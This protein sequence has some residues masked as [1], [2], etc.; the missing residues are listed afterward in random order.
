MLHVICLYNG[1]IQPTALVFIKNYHN[2]R[3]A[4]TM[5]CW[6]AWGLRFIFLSSISLRITTI[7]WVARF[8][9]LYKTQYYFRI[10]TTLEKR[11]EKIYQKK[12]ICIHCG[13]VGYEWAFSSRHSIYIQFFG[14][15]RCIF[16]FTKLIFLQKK[17]KKIGENMLS[18]AWNCAVVT[19][20]AATLLKGF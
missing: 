2:R 13:L 8:L 20:V 9:A 18:W 3:N 4:M 10:T 16:L 6:L 12:L 15:L 19:S 17:S 11:F 5:S 14:I 1:K 7:L